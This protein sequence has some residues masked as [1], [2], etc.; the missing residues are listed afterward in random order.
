MN[1]ETKT[2]KD[3]GVFGR[4]VG[5]FTAP[6]DAFISIDA[7]PTWLVPFLITT[8]IILAL[9]VWTLD[10]NVKDQLAAWERMDMP[11]EQFEQMKA[12]T[13]GPFRY[14]GLA[15]IPVSTLAV[16]AILAGIY[17]FG[18]NTIMG[19]EGKY[20]K[21]F[22]VMAWTSLIG[23]LGFIVNRIL[24]YSKGTGHGV[25]TSLAAL[26]PTP[27]VGESPPVLYRALSQ[28]D[29]FGIWSLVVMIIGFAI[30]SRVEMKKSAILVI[31]LWL[32]YVLA[33]V[34]LGGLF[35]RMMGG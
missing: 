9:S 21:V 32:I 7:R 30:V 29:L 31:V 3:M 27:A 20:K 14:I 23:T 4:I 10:I 8:I 5:I 12:R 6:K 34:L 25:T 15:F 24:V 17:L 11:Q 28:F 22:S 18:F 33:A 16:W 13:E 26:L 35:G 2:G 1:A 19:G